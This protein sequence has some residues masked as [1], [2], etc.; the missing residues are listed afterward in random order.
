ML[1]AAALY[2]FDNHFWHACKLVV[3]EYSLQLRRVCLSRPCTSEKSRT[4]EDF[5]E[6]LYR[7]RGGRLQTF[8]HAFHCG[9]SGTNTDVLH[10]LHSF[11]STSGTHPGHALAQAVSYPPPT[12][13]AWIQTQASCVGFMVDEVA[14]GEEFLRVLWCSLVTLPPIHCLTR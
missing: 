4:A 3:C 12:T 13:E 11:L 9:Q 1:S 7:E 5:Q 10:G 6:R 8:V 2:V 14:A